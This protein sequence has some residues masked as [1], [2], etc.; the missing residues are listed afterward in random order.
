VAAANQA[1]AVAKG[2][3]EGPSINEPQRG[4]EGVQGYDDVYSDDLR[5]IIHRHATKVIKSSTYRSFGV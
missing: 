2:V 5:E 4:G 3:R 1:A